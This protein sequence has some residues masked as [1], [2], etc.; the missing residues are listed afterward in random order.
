MRRNSPTSDQSTPAA[1]RFS[2]L[3]IRR[4]RDEGRTIWQKLAAHVQERLRLVA[5]VPGGHPIWSERRYVVFL[6]TPDDVYGRIRYI[7][8]NPA[9]EGMPPQHWSFVQTYDG[10]PRA[11]P[12]RKR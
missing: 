9:K 12:T 5:D 10:W 1:N 2:R 7:E 8:G 4:H 6:Y 11:E 3:C